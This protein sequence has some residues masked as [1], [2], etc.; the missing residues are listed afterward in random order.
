ME[1]KKNEKKADEDVLKSIIGN[2]AELSIHYGGYEIIVKNKNEFRWAEVFECLFDYGYSVY[3]IK[4]DNN[5]NIIAK[6]TW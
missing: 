4:R 1:E 5:I 2:T 3:V 6:Q